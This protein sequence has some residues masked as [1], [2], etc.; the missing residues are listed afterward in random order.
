MKKKLLAISVFL[1]LYLSLFAQ[2]YSAGNEPFSI[3]WKQIQTE[4]FQIIF[5]EEFEDKAQDFAAKMDYAYSYVNKSMPSKPRKLS[6]IIHSYSAKSNGLVSWAPRRMELWPTPSQASNNYSQDW[7]DQLILHETRHFVQEN[8]MN[9]GFTK[10]LKIIFGEQGEMIPLGL[11]TR[12]WFMEGDAVATETALSKSGRGRLPSFEQGLRALTL[13]KGI[14]GYDEAHLGTYR[15]YVPNYYEVGYH[16]VAVNRLQKDSLIFEKKMNQFPRF[17]TWRGFRDGGKTNYYGFAIDY[18]DKEW[19]KQDSLIAKT[20]YENI[21][22][23]NDDYCSYECLQEDKGKFY[24]I[25]NSYS[26]IS[27]LVSIDSLG[28]EN[29]IL[30][31]GWLNEESVDIL[32]GKICYVDEIPNPRWENCSSADIFIYDIKSGEKTRITKKQIYQAPTQNSDA[33]KILAQHISDDGKYELRILD[34]K[35][36]AVLERIPNPNQQYYSSFTWSEDDSAIAYVAQENDQKCIKYYNLKTEEEQVLI[37][38]S[39]E[40]ISSLLFDGDTI[41]YTGSY[42]GINNIYACDVNTKQVTRLTS[43]RFAADFATVLDGKLYYSNYTSDGFKPVKHLASD[44]AGEQLANVKY[45]GLGLGDKLTKQEGGIVDFSKIDTTSYEIKKYSRAAHLFNI[46]SWFPLLTVEDNSPKINYTGE[47]L[48]YPNL[49]LL[50]QNKLSTSFLTAIYN[51]NPARSSERFKLSYSYE[52][53]YPKLGLDL[54]F[55]SYEVNVPAY[56]WLVESFNIDVRNIIVRPNIS[57]P[58]TFKNGEYYISLNN[59]LFGEYVHLN[60]MQLHQKEDYFSVGVFSS[61][62]RSHQRAVRDLFTPYLQSLSLRLSYDDFSNE[63]YSVAASASV[64]TPG[65]FN[66]HSLQLKASYQH[67]YIKSY[68]IISNLPRGY[69]SS[70]NTDVAYGSVDYYFP[71]AYPDWNLGSFLYLKR[72]SFGLYVDAA[73]IVAE[74]KQNEFLGAGGSFFMDMNFIRYEADIRLGFQIGVADS[75]FSE[76]PIMP[77]NLI[78]NFSIF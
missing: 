48:L 62:T 55:G 30:K 44:V 43:A 77:T 31:L 15:N 36:G 28:N 34:A 59:T 51:A 38:D 52:G 74:N 11:Y 54:A 32:N 69:S 42:T 49:T 47:S 17:K 25:K 53:F 75:P 2:Y 27:E 63:K 68:N 39:Y 12:Q 3:N 20:P 76:K 70:D 8:K 56:P 45:I 29:S 18:L 57:I 5:P 14:Q 73:L 66:H 61:F 26:S 1:S 37:A 22:Q 58:S 71:V 35:D 23:E 24:A 40:E 65:I 67:K 72:C 4:Y 46:H 41:Y 21:L 10:V 9:Q 60:Y 33:S 64:F 50:S 19:R 16:T 6:V 13:E 78:L 7:M